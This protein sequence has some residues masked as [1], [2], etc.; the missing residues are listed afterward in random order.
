MTLTAIDLFAG[1]GGLTVGLKRA[2]F[3]VVSAV[4]SDR[5]AF[6][7][8]TA[9]HPEVRCINQDVRT[10]SGTGLLRFAETEQSIC[11]PVAHRVKG[12]NR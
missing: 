10:V 1:A 7:T 6:A 3:R 9:N 8:Y 11:W 2:G 5:H 4:E 12:C